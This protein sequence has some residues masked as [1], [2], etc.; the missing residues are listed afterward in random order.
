V[1]FVL[2]G[3]G[4]PGRLDAYRARATAL[5]N[6]HLPGPVAPV[7][8]GP[9][10]QA[11]DA[12]LVPHG[13]ASERRYTSPLKIFE[14]M[15]A[16]RPIVASDLAAT[17]E[18]LEDGASAM[19][20]EPDVPQAFA[21]ALRRVLEAPDLAGRLATTAR[22][23]VVRHTWQQ[24]A[25]RIVAAAMELRAPRR[26]RLVHVINSFH[27]LV[28]G[29]ERQAAALARCQQEA[30]DQVEIVT[31]RRSG[32]PPL[33]G[34]GPLLVRRLGQPALRGPGFLVAALVH[35]LR[36]HR[37]ADVVHAH[38]ARAPALVAVLARR[39]GGPPAVVKLAGL[40]L[41]RGRGPLT[42]LR[43]RALAA[44]DAVVA[45]QPAMAAAL[46]G[47]GLERLELIPNGVDADHFA[48]LKAPAAGRRLP[49][50]EG[51]PALPRVLFVGRLEPVKGIDLLLEAWRRRSPGAPAAHLVI[52]G[53][54]SLAG[55]VRD[56]C[57]PTVS[58][59][60]TVDDPAA[61]YRA[62]DLLVVP[63][64]S[65]GLS[66][67]LLEGM[68]TGLAVVASAVG[69]NPSLITDGVD[70][71]LVEAENVAALGGA[72]DALLA[73]AARRAVLGRAARRT[74]E[75]DYRLERIEARWAAL[76]AGLLASGSRPAKAGT[77]S[78]SQSI[79]SSRSQK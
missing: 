8:V 79:R 42:A 4:A 52:A 6:V 70:G 78:S 39:V 38:Q 40:D 30:G 19:L 27:P 49:G 34:V 5:P 2:V 22:Q 36:N 46:A 74:I 60:G 61:L 14:A 17:R 67:V 28:G 64:R 50:L 63:S 31:R 9:L 59:I 3:D 16:G 54:G 10:L 47:L 7:A 15:A 57:G 56:A 45:T 71:C 13:R 68:A 62:V 41:P 58:W 53:D 65:E 20:V 25:R 23:R 72:V 18:V 73:D 32:L 35:L 55:P 26:R 29:A 12:V 48:P 37:G 44:A 11:A 1:Q 76:Y 69:G 51:A 33:D 24:R 21:A 43:R 77:A 75:R 66:N